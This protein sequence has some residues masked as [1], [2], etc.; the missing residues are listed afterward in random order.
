MVVHAADR[1]LRC[2][3]CGAESAIP[4]ACP[5]CGNV[6]LKPVGRGTQRVEETL[7]A[8]FPEAR[9]VRIDRDSAARRAELTR[10]LESVHRGEADIL[11]GTQLLAKGHDFP[12]LTLVASEYGHRAALDRLPGPRNASSPC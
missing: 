3:H 9:I 2:H 12:K 10:V 11:V 5:T 4:R 1:R 6:D 7:A 8:R